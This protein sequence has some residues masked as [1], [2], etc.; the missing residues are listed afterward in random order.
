MR[1]PYAVL[2]LNNQ[3]KPEEIKSAFRKLAKQYHPDHNREDPRAQERFAE[4]NQAY[5][6]LG[7]KDKRRQFDRGEINAEGK[8]NF[9]AGHG[10]GGGGGHPFADFA[11]HFAQGAAGARGGGGTQDFRGS[12]FDADDLFFRD[13]FGRDSAKTSGNA[14]GRAASGA[15]RRGAD[16]TTT[17]AITL[18]Q[19]AGAENVEVVFANGKRLKIKLPNFVEEGQTI[20]LKGQG[21]VGRGGEAGDALVTI[22]FKSHPR[23]RLEGRALHLD[24]PVSLKGAVIGTREEVETLDGRIVI[25]IPPWS[26]S[27]KV[28]RL[29]AKGLPEKNGERADLYV[30]VRIML[31]ET[32]DHDLEHYLQTRY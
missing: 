23:F 2:G 19:A 27:D 13:L 6:I 29:R 24:L 14:H 22:A 16:I 4:I 10:M 15:P 30:H 1:N 28:L 12:H 17:L 20:R 9:N 21:E 8:R 18:E 3:A 26:S 31:P 7:D 25:A 11:A 5:E 32:R